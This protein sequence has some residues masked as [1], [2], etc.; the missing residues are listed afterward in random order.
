MPLRDH[1]TFLKALLRNPT[2]IGAVAPSS[3]ALA[4]AMVRGLDVAR[5]QSVLEFGPG[6]GPF[7]AALSSQVDAPAQYLG[8]ERDE[9]FVT[10]LRARFPEMSFVNGSA[11]DA[12]AIHADAGLPPV[13]AILCGLPFA[14]L[15]PPVQD[16]VIASIDQLIPVGGCFRTFQYVHA[17]PLPAAIRF[18]GRMESIFGRHRRQAVVCKNV[19]PAFV[20]E[21][22]R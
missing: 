21:W 14:S 10:H 1:A 2:H 16:G 17:Y 8:I 11:E 22:S 5:G 19:P 12:Q 3:P 4:R 18:R 15:P 6:T 20:L 13:K 7:T 9:Q